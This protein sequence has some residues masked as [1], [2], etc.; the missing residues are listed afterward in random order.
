MGLANTILWFIALIL[1]VW[2]AS[3]CHSLAAT[4]RHISCNSVRIPLGN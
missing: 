1:I 4:Y 3:R 2:Y